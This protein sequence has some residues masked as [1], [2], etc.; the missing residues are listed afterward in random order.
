MSFTIRKEFTL[1]Q[2]IVGMVAVVSFLGAAYSIAD[3][4]KTLKD[5]AKTMASK[6]SISTLSDNVKEIRSDIRDIRLL[7]E[8]HIAEQDSIDRVQAWLNRAKK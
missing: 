1:G 7:V 2:I 5:E 8:H 3:D 4:V 6:E